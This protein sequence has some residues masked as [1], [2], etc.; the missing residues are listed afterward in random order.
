[1]FPRI[2]EISVKRVFN[3]VT[4]ATSSAT[5]SP[6]VDLKEVDGHFSLQVGLTGDGTGKMEYELSNDGTTYRT[7]TSATDIVTSHVKTSGPSSDGKDLYPF[8]PELGRFL[9]IKASN[10]DTGDDIVVTVHLAL[11]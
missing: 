6:F 7:P 11:K 8:E 3:G 10:T 1:M 5:T 9:K 4:I 2:K